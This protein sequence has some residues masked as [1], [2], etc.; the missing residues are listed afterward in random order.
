MTCRG[1]LAKIKLR[2]MD[3]PAG[4][5]LVQGFLVCPRDR[6]VH[7]VPHLRA[8]DALQQ[9]RVVTAH[10]KQPQ[11]SHQ[12]SLSGYSSSR[13]ARSPK[14]RV[15]S[16]GEGVRRL[17]GELGGDERNTVCEL[18]QNRALEVGQRRMPYDSSQDAPEIT[19]S[20]AAETSF[21]RCCCV[22]MRQQFHHLKPGRRG[23]CACFRARSQV[24]RS[25][26]KFSFTV[27]IYV[28]KA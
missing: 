24:S 4:Q 9:K 18:T 17:D 1:V 11:E 16:G 21:A 22:K 28:F 10:A 13:R 26:A 14:R 15:S 20:S 2:G 8:E 3:V 7:E 19:L 25:R 27:K 6:L 23:L 5:Q 12:L